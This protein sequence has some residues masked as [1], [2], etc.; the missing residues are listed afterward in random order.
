MKKKIAFIIVSLILI[1]F[2]FYAT[3]IFCL[4][5]SKGIV[6]YA[7]YFFSSFY[8]FYFVLLIVIKRN[9]IK[10]FKLYLK[11]HKYFNKLFDYSLRTTIIGFSSLILNVSYAIF[12]LVVSLLYKQIWY[13]AQFIYYFTL[14][15]LR[16]LIVGVRN[17]RLKRNFII[18]GI[19]LVIMPLAISPIILQVI[20]KGS[21]FSYPGYLI[22]AVAFYTFYRVIMGIYN[23]H[24]AKR[25]KNP[26]VMAL[27]NIS[28][29]SA[30]ISLFALQTAM[31]HDFGNNVNVLVW[32]SITSSLVCLITVIIGINMLFKSRNKK[33]WLKTEN[34][35]LYEEW[36]LF[37]QNEFH[38]FIL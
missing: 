26:K 28:M 15:V 19:M 7:Y 3:I 30:L 22:Y 34:S 35:N 23:I 5:D 13:G 9:E 16:F 32:N 24:K 17:K 10:K 4:R 11:E 37:I 31:L 8:L 29:A 18:V 25:T 38:F 12:A 14:I 1:I 33:Y 36:N 2:S 6:V 21:N 27:R 20:Y